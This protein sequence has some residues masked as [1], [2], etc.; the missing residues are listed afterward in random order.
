MQHIKATI[1]KQNG[2]RRSGRGFSLNELGKAGLTKQ[3][4]KRIG[5]PLDVKRRSEH[6]ENIMTLKEHAAKAKSE[7]KPKAPK[8]KPKAEHTE[9]PK[10]KAKS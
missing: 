2:K 6:E 1:I 10:K 8:N 5:I 7:A 9:K 3:D 4:A